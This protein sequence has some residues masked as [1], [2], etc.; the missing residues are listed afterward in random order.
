M[1]REATKEDSKIILSFLEKFGNKSLNERT[2]FENPFIHYIVLEEEETIGFLS[3]THIYER[4]ELEY[5]YVKDEYQNNGYAQILMD[6]FIEQAI[7]NKIESITLEVGVN[8][9]KALSLYKKYKFEIISTREKYYGEENAY[10]LF[11][12][13]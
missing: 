6:A 8:N 11:R 9:K 5:I 13:L 7:K 10:L 4:C 12:K 2:L 3:Y 1:L